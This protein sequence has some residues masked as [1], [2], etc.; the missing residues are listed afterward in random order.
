MKPFYIF[1]DID[2]VLAPNYC[3]ERENHEIFSYKWDEECVRVLN[4]F[5]R[6]T[7]A[8]IILSSD[9]RL[10]Y[11]NDI[12]M[13]DHLFK[14]NNVISSPIDV[15]PS[16]GRNHREIEIDTYIKDNNI[17]N[18][19]ILDDEKLTIYPDRFLL[20]DPEVGIKHSYDRLL[21]FFGQKGG[22]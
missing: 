3:S 22:A 12:K 10:M 9:W 16:F 19:T 21:K 14:Y 17:S 7:E 6:F 8:K 5:L 20:C 11:S 4:K 15:T 13:I 2:G 18:F 1:L